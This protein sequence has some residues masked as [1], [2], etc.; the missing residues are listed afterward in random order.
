MAPNRRGGANPAS[1]RTRPPFP[2]RG[3]LQ[4]A[5]PL[6]LPGRPRPP[7]GPGLEAAAAATTATPRLC[8]VL[9][10]RSGRGAVSACVARAPEAF[11]CGPCCCR[12]A[13]AGSAA[14]PAPPRRAPPPRPPFQSRAALR[15]VSTRNSGGFSDSRAQT[16]WGRLESNP[17]PNFASPSLGP[18]GLGHCATCLHPGRPGGGCECG[19]DYG[20]PGCKGAWRQICHCVGDSGKRAPL[21]GAGREEENTLTASSE[22]RELPGRRER[23]VPV[24]SAWPEG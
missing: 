18:R 15:A 22:E 7:F 16:S 1:G 14:S 3:F 12:A 4:P 21:A 2:A 9:D 20:G 8:R 19:R 13:G 17:A 10:P 5:P 6:G 11:V 23:V 24:H